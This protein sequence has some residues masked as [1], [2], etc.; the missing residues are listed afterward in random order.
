[1]VCLLVW[2]FVVVVIAAVV[3]IRLFL[4]LFGLVFVF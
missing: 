2:F 4:G 3:L 1:M